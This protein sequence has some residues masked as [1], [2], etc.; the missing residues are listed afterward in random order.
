M[1][2]L[3]DNSINLQAI[4]D[5]V[6]ALPE[7]GGGEG[8]GAD[9]AP[10]IQVFTGTI[11]PTSNTNLFDVPSEAEG[12]P[13]IFAS[14]IANDGSYISDSAKFAQGVVCQLIAVNGTNIQACDYNYFTGQKITTA[15]YPVIHE[16][17]KQIAVASIAKS[18]FKN[19]YT[20]NYILLTI[21]KLTAVSY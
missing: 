14:W 10:F 21:D 9:I 7:A 2:N 17:G 4:L 12:T 16:A 5:M 20:Y 1:S 15:T 13:A 18:G 6:N 19:G 3:S 8:G 11:T